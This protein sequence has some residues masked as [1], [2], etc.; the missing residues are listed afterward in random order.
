V[1][2]IVVGVDGSTASRAALRWAAD[3]AHRLGAGLEVVQVWHYPPDLHEWDAM[4]SNYGYLPMV[5]PAERVELG[6]HD[7]LAATV[8]EVLGPKPVCA[9]RQRVIEGHPGRVLADVADG[10]TL[11]VVGRC[12]HGG[13][14]GMLLGSVARACS[15][16]AD[17]PV[18]VVPRPRAVRDDRPGAPSSDVARPAR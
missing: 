8:A 3:L 6:V 12:G 9:V 13:L 7:D 18:V 2:H 14:A 16:H 10:A 4:P 17:C 5:P 11:L 1:E 15:E